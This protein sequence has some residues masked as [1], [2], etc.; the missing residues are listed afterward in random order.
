MSNELSVIRS[1]IDSVAEKFD[2]LR[3]DKHLSFAAEAGF[4]MQTLMSN[5]YALSV[6]MQN[7]QSVINAVQCL[8]YRRK[9]HL[10]GCLL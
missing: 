6:A 2:Q 1:D 10:C 7:R 4:A 3:V 8:N 5:E 9:C